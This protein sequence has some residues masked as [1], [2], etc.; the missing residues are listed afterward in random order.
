MVR[1]MLFLDGRTF[2]LFIHG[3]NR[4]RLPALR[5][6]PADQAKEDRNSDPEGC[7][8]GD[9]I[10]QLRETQKKNQGTADCEHEAHES[11]PDGQ[12]MHADAGMA[13][14]SHKRTPLT[15]DHR[16]NPFKVQTILDSSGRVH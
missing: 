9:E 16:T 7:A 1:S 14:F 5:P 2:S 3:Q 15:S 13:V 4:E 8:E 12:F 10:P 11:R 6:V